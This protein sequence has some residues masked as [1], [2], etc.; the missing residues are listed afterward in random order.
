MTTDSGK[1]PPK[2]YGMTCPQCGSTYGFLTERR[3]NGDSKCLACDY[4]DSTAFFRKNMADHCP[5][6]ERLEDDYKDIAN[7]LMDSESWELKLGEENQ[8]L[9]AQLAMCK[10]ALKYYRGSDDDETSWMEPDQYVPYWTL[11]H[12]G[13]NVGGKVASECMEKLE[14]EK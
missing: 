1:K 13:N 3:P 11:W 14:G 6:C 4:K 8:K 2:D 5:N 12:D 7:R 10:E 9:K